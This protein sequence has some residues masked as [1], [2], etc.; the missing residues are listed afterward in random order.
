MANFPRFASPVAR[1][2]RV[3]YRAIR[4]WFQTGSATRPKLPED[5][6]QPFRDS[7]DKRRKRLISLRMDEDLLALSKELARQHGLRYQVVLRLWIQE[8]LRRAIRE[9]VEDPERCPFP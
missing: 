2:W 4:Q 9:G 1:E 8:G 7:S 5:P 3:Y 6:L